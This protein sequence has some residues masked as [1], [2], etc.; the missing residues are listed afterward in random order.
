MTHDTPNGTDKSTDPI[1]GLFQSARRNPPAPTTDFMARMLADALAA[2]AAS[3]T[4]APVRRRGL[5]LRILAALGGGFGVAGLGTAALA[6]VV[7]GYV[8]PDP[9]L[10]LGEQF[11]VT[12]DAASLDLSYGFDTVFS[13]DTA[14]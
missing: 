2:Q 10:V 1:E 7:I 4:P 5:W 6:G 8:Q 11:G 9:L 12:A 3:S 13:E 14:P